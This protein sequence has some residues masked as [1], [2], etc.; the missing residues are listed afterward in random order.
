MPRTWMEINTSSL[1]ITRMLVQSILPDI[2]WVTGAD[3]DMRIHYPGFDNPERLPSDLRDRLGEHKGIPR[4][5][6]SL[7]VEERYRESALHQT[8]INRGEYP[9]LFADSSLGVYIS[10]VYARTRLEIRFQYR[11]E[12]EASARRHLQEVLR[13]QALQQD[14]F[15]HEAR[16]HYLIPAAAIALLRQIHDLREKQAGYDDSIGTYLKE[17]FDRQ[18][19]VVSN[20]SGK[21]K[22]FAKE[23]V[24]TNI[25][26]RFDQIEPDRNIERADDN[27]SVNAELTY[28]V[29]FD[30]VLG[31]HLTYPITIHNQPLPHR[32]QDIAASVPW[33]LGHRLQKRSKFRRVSDAWTSNEKTRWPHGSIPVPYFLDWFPPTKELPDTLRPVLRIATMIDSD[34]SETMLEL[35]DLE[36]EGIGTNFLD[37]LA[38]EGSSLLELKDSFFHFKLYENDAPIDSNRLE[39]EDDKLLYPLTDEDGDPLEEDDLEEEKR[40]R[41]RCRYRIAL[42]LHDTHFK[43]N[44][45][46]IDALQPYPKFA[47]DLACAINP[48]L[49]RHRPLFKGSD[50]YAPEIGSSDK[51]KIA[52]RSEEPESALKAFGII[53]HDLSDSELRSQVRRFRESPD[54]EG[55][56]MALAKE[57]GYEV[58]TL[59][60]SENGLKDNEMVR[61]IIT[62]DRIYRDRLRRYQKEI[63]RDRL[64][65][66]LDYAISPWQPRGGE[67]RFDQFDFTPFLDTT[68][69]HDHPTQ[70]DPQP[71]YSR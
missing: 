64:I 7:E 58:R 27:A 29:D 4:A 42:Y 49:E 2:V 36:D 35:Y 67:V 60:R 59:A 48:E 37:F 26:G 50:H 43:L 51:E 22:R 54:Y 8:V 44:D 18:I 68:P 71:P 69:H 39:W 6:I 66:V 61:W 52:E 33:E 5:D 10:P 1:N 3:P 25:L 17:H 38:S 55:F 16:Y 53:E 65:E 40:R 70:I 30:K 31:L 41:L 21:H 13:R 15:I 47:E 56:R 46:A 28:L 23:E 11:F 62:E 24:Q 57:K 20:Q 34:D 14:L 63:D 19:T 9:T 12:G 45:R 32:Y